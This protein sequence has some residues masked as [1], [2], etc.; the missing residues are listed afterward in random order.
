MKFELL[1]ALE[2]VIC[3]TSSAASDENLIK[4]TTFLFQWKTGACFIDRE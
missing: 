1:A 4:T 2:V 3:T